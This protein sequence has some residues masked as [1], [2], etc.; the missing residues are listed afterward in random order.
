[1]LHLYEKKG[2]QVTIRPLAHKDIDYLREWRNQSE[3]SQ[4][5]RKI[6]HISKAM[7]EQWFAEYL[8]SNDEMTFAIVYEGEVSGSASLYGFQRGKAEFGKLMVGRNKGKGIGK[9]ATRMCLDIAFDDLGLDI[10]E[11]VVTVGNTAAVVIYVKLGF[12]ITGRRFSEDVGADEYTIEL[13]KERY[14]ALRAIST[15][16][17]N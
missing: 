7:Q 5:I 4:F 3:N 9:I 8:E 15:P 11:A 12:Y 17:A 10:V 6:P 2:D 14:Y 16:F 13:P 1:M